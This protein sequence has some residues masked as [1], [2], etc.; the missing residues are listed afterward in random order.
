METFSKMIVVLKLLT[1]APQLSNL[2]ESIA[3]PK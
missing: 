2:L 3:N 1:L